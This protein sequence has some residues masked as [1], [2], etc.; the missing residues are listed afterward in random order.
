[1]AAKGINI[2]EEC[3]VVNAIAPIDIN[4][5]GPD[6]DVWSMENYSHCSIIVQLGV[7][8]G[9]TTITVEECDDFTPHN[10][11]AI[12]F[13][14]SAE[15]T[16]AGD[17]LGARTAATSSGITGSTNDGVM[18]VIEIDASELTDGYP[19]LRVRFSDPTEATVVSAVAILSGSRYATEASPTAIA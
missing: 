12:A 15:V 6:S 2:A 9:A 4:G 17:T 5:V 8:G 16:A 1:M 19:N 7:T 11:T 18:Y 10:S 14:N 3:H 13:Y